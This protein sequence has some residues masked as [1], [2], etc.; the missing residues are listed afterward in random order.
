MVKL[1]SVENIE[2]NDITVMVGYDYSNIFENDYIMIH[3]Y[4][5]NNLH[6]IEQ[7]SWV[8]S[9][10]KNYYSMHNKII[11]ITNSP[12]ILC[13]IETTVNRNHIKDKCCY[14]DTFEELNNCTDSID[15]IYKKL[16]KPLEYLE[17]ME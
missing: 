3:K 14:Y 1:N 17:Y 16:Y 13:A 6:P 8:E 4:P 5:E 11:I 12:Y 9:V 15:Y 10:F 2:L 7:V